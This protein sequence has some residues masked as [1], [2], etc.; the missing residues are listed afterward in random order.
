[1]LRTVAIAVAAIAV[2]ACGTIFRPLAGPL[3]TSG[4]SPDW[5]EYYQSLPPMVDRAPIIVRGIVTR[6]GTHDE[7]YGTM[8]TIVLRRTDVLKGSAP[9][10]IAVIESPCPMYDARE[11]DEWIA[12]LQPFFSPRTPRDAGIYVS[13]GGPQAVFAVRGGIVA[14]SG[15]LDLPQSVVG[16]YEGKSGSSLLADIR[17]VRPLDGDAAA[18]FSR[19]GWTTRGNWRVSEVTL[20]TAAGMEDVGMLAPNTPSKVP[21]NFAELAAVS[22]DAGLD[23]RLSGGKP[24]EL[25][26]L[27]LERDWDGTGRFPPLGTVL[28]V[29]RRIVGAWVHIS[30]QGDLY[31]LRQRVEA[32]AAPPHD[33]PTPTPIPN[34]FPQGVNIARD[35][36]LGV[37]STLSV[38]SPLGGGR[39][40]DRAIIKPI[41]DALD[42][43]LPTFAVPGPTSGTPTI[44]LIWA[45]DRF[46]TLE[47]WPESD[48]LVNRAFGYAVHPPPH[49]IEL[50]A[51]VR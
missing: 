38:K 36:G 8:R 25:L 17:A 23:F 43:T 22:A 27:L 41:V 51:T 29:D 2:M 14:K 34:R 12:F 9:A 1:M 24:G 35:H 6:I 26:D 16:A 5:V 15:P 49:A 40:E 45:E 33:P 28:I 32:L 20:P 50:L 10:E 11:G 18:L 48:L 13:L 31:S 42:V 47:Y 30:P 7:E 44:L 19:F 37:A 4:C 46:L 39:T 21:Q 3:T